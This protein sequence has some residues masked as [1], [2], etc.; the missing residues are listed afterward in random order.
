MAKN[1][2]PSVDYVKPNQ[3]VSLSE[4]ET[5]KPTASQDG[6][7]STNMVDINKRADTKLT[8][9]QALELRAKMRQ[10]QD[11]DRTLKDGS[12]INSKSDAIR[13]MIENPLAQ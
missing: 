12:R 7:L 4:G 13:W 11:E 8:R 10:M 2:L 3:I 6:Y 5:I 1:N 9:D